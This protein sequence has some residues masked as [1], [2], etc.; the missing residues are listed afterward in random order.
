[1]AEERRNSA[2][3]AVSAA[4]AGK[5]LSKIAKGAATGGATGATVAAGSE[6]KKLLIPILALLMVPIVI[7]AMLP[8]IIFGSLIGDG[9]ASQSGITSDAVLTD[10]MVRQSTSIS[11]VLSEGLQ[12]VLDRIDQNF[13]SSGCDGKEIN[14]P[15]GSDIRYNANAILSQYCASMDNSAADI[16]EA[17]MAA[18]LRSN[19][20]KLY[21]FTFHDETHEVT[22]PSDDPEEEDEVVEETIRVYEISYNGESYFADQIFRLTQPQKELAEQYAHNLAVFLSDGSRQ[23]LADSDYQFSGTVYDGVTFTDGGISV[24][25][26]NQLD[27]RWKDAAYGTDNIGGYGCGP[28]AMSIVVSTLTGDTVDP[29]TMAGWAYDHGYWCSGNGSY[30]TLIAAAADAW[31]LSVEGCTAEEPQRLVD[32][33]GAG[34]LVVAIMGPGHFTKSGHFIVL[35][36]C[37]A[38]GQLFVADP[39]SFSRSEKSWDLSVVL[40]EASK[41]TAANGPFWIIGP[42]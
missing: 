18:I 2:S 24:T 22:I 25:Y 27:G 16:S 21:S 31:G 39:A 41:S 5:A 20:D 7:V 8:S 11:Q 6:L 35:R 38:E 36:G 30:R 10:N 19:V 4:K 29:P 23:V 28:T 1:M 32:A 42:R 9:S 34:K 26:Y 33:L 13:A 17:D 15:Y 40:S 12:E 3:N 14:N 37:T